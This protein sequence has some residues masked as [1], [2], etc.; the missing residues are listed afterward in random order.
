MM[1]YF[2]GEIR[3]FAGNYVPW[4]WLLCDGTILPQAAY[5]EL[6]KVIGNTFG[7]SGSTFNLPNLQ[8]RVTLG[9]GAAP[10][11]SPYALGEQGGAYQA[12]LGPDNL[13]SHKHDFNGSLIASRKVSQGSPAN[14]YLGMP[15]SVDIYTDVIDKG[16]MA[17]DMVAARTT[18]EGNNTP[19]AFSVLQ[20]YLPLTPI[21]AKENYPE[22]GSYIGEVRLFAGAVPPEG[23]MLCD[24]R[25]LDYQQGNEVL[26]AIIEHAYG[27]EGTK[28][29]LPN[30]CGR[31]AVHPDTTNKQSPLALGQTGGNEQQVLTIE[32][33]PQH[34]H[35][36]QKEATILVTDHADSNS[37]NLNYFGWAA[38]SAYD[39]DPNNATSSTGTSSVQGT[40]DY[41]GLPTP[42]PVSVR[43]PYLGLNYII[44]CEGIFPSQP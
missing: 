5:P 1:Y 22:D 29:N 43:Q 21:I 25:T 18:I 14:A 24:G 33:M 42:R 30:L 16:T 4:G 19:A 26:F 9:A 2:A 28:F 15:E 39:T 35:A 34:Q 31:V 17:R 10:G 20:P 7:G 44:C 37:P 8:G 41:Y 38:F 27:G 32:T 36:A 6:Y 40:T 11:L 23:W 13:P 12:K 3:F